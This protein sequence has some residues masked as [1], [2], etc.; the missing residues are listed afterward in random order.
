[1]RIIPLIIIFFF[2]VDRK[3]IFRKISTL[4][5]ISTLVFFII[6]QNNYYK[7]RFINQT[8]SSLAKNDYSFTHYFKFSI[9]GA[10]YNAAYQV[11]KDYPLFGVGLKNFRIES[12][13]TKYENKDFRFTEK[14]QNTHPHQIHL[15]F[16]SEL[17]LFG[18]SLILIIFYIFLKKSIGIQIKNKNLYHLSGILFLLVFFIPLIPTGSFFTTYGAAIFWLNFSIIEAFN[19]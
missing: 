3:F 18:Y 14:R 9:Y 7:D 19:D 17:G 8:F 4:A 16:L 2:I 5:V 15:E 6:A 12:G 11:F 1:L 10:H 13:R